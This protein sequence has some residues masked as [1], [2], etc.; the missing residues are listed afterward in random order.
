MGIAGHSSLRGHAVD[1]ESGLS[2]AA[3]TADVAALPPPRTG[4]LSMLQILTRSFT[5][6]HPGRTGY[7]RTA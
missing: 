1:G 5:A 4:E 3:C 2:R 7:R 6:A